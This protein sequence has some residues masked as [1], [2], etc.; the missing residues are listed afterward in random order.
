MVSLLGEERERKLGRIC[1]PLAVLA[2]TVDLVAI[3][4]FRRGDAAERGLVQSGRPP[5]SALLMDRLLLRDEQL[6][7]QALERITFQLCG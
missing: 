5:F 6:E 1:D 2:A 7:Y 4:N 3:V